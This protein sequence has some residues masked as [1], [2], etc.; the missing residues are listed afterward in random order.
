MSAEAEEQGQAPC[1]SP[2]AG[3]RCLSRSATDGMWH[4]TADLQRSDLIRELLI[5]F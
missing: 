1:S 2:A 5:G 4:V 3:Q